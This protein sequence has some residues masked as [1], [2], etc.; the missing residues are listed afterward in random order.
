MTI[1]EL[2][3]E[4]SEITLMRLFEIEVTDKRTKETDYIIFDITIEDDKLLAHHVSLTIEEENSKF[5]A[6]KEVDLDDCFSLDENLQY[7]YEECTT[8]ILDSDFYNLI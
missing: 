2:K 5:I 7:L 4:F 3:Q 1:K 6:Y 8:A